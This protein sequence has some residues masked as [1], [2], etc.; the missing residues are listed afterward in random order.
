MAVYDDNNGFSEAIKC[1]QSIP[2]GDEVGPWMARIAADLEIQYRC[3]PT[4]ALDLAMTASRCAIYLMLKQ[5]AS[6]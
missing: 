2:P 5:R 4:T 3:S 1:W 6:L